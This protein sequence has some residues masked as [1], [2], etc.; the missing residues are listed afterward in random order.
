MKRQKWRN[1]VAP[2][3]YVLV[4]KRDFQAE[5]NN[6]VDIIM[7]YSPEAMRKL[8]NMNEIPKDDGECEE[9]SVFVMDEGGSKVAS[10]A[11][12]VATEEEDTSNKQW[13]VDFD[14]I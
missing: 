3:D 8:R 5:D 6:K 9:E 12:A 7:K 11:A 4:S 10:K 14:D 2:N 13:Q 1:F